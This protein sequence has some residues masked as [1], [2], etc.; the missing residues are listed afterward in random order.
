MVH[1]DATFPWNITK[2]N[3]IKK[4]KE[5]QENTAAREADLTHW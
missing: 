5:S 4:K 3:Q 1:M 2:Q